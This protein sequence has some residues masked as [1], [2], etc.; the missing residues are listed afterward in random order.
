MDW[1]GQ[2][3]EIE[4]EDLTFLNNL[5]SDDSFGADPPIGSKSIKHIKTEENVYFP[6]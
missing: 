6:P 5:D 2:R 3:S 1:A 4:I